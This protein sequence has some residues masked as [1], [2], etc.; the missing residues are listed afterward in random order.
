MTAAIG[1]FIAFTLGAFVPLLPYLLTSGGPAFVASLV[2]S[3]AA[4]AL[5][6]F[7]ISRLTRR[8]AL[9]SVTRQVLLGGAAAAVTYAVGSF[10]GV[11]LA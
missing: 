3:L 8:S 10:I 6:G 11:Q 9:F 5:L 7:G 2:A 1:S 4:L